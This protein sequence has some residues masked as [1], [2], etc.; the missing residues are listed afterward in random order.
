MAKYGVRTFVL[1]VFFIFLLFLFIYNLSLVYMPS[2]STARSAVATAFVLA[3]IQRK[4]RWR[5]LT[6]SLSASFLAFLGVVMICLVYSFFQ[7]FFSSEIDVDWIQFSRIVHFIVY[8]IFGAYLFSMLANFQIERLLSWFFYASFIQAIF[9]VLSYLNADFRSL[10]A[11][12]LVQS[13]N[14]DLE[15]VVRSS[16]LSNGLGSALSLIQGLGCFAGAVVLSRDAKFC[17]RALLLVLF[18]VLLLSTI[19]TGRVGLILGLI[20]TATLIPKLSK[21]LLLFVFVMFCVASYQ[22]YSAIDSL[23]FAERTFNWAFEYFIEGESSSVGELANMPIPQFSIDTVLG[24]GRVSL[25]DGSNASGHDSGY[26][27]T[28][29]ALGGVFSLIFYL[30]FFLFFAKAAWVFRSLFLFGLLA[31][32][33]VV[34]VKEP[35]IFKYILAFFLFSIYFCFMVGSKRAIDT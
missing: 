5:E 12:L 10:V 14:I 7:V 16:G 1:D 34:E 4:V 28:Y 27:Q 17:K 22:I 35:F 25:P 23:P 24:L 2:L 30:S 33:I 29:Y 20:A 18:F 21:G 26:I 11:N 13:G 15:S 32:A 3:L 6:S 8:S 9:V 31:I 19:L